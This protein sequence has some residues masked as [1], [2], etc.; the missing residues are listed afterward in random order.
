ML[1]FP[2]L[3]TRQPAFLSYLTFLRDRQH[4]NTPMPLKSPW[5]IAFSVCLSDPCLSG[6]FV[7]PFSAYPLNVGGFPRCDISP[8]FSSRG[9]L[10]RIRVTLSKPLAAATSLWPGPMLSSRTARLA[11][12]ASMSTSRPP[13][14]SPHPSCS[15]TSLLLCLAEGKHIG[16]DI[17]N[18][19]LS[20]LPFQSTV[21]DQGLSSAQ[22]LFFTLS[23][24]H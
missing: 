6:S 2:I 13:D 1:P 19:S 5:A 9:T 14:L 22:H 8:L 21:G 20:P 4:L 15:I 12:T 24:P 17:R 18:P 7:R 11:D 23:H 3:F 10:H 16:T